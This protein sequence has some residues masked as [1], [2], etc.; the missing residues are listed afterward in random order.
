LLIGHTTWHWMGERYTALREA[1]WQP[2]SVMLTQPPFLIALAVALLL[3]AGWTMRRRRLRKQAI[4]RT[5]YATKPST[6][7]V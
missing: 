2:G 3:A 1:D 7:T 4:E 5:G 6:T